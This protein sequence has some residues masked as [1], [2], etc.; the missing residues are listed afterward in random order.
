MM[1]N[2]KSS[3]TSEPDV[4]SDSLADVAPCLQVDEPPV[5]VVL[6]QPEIPQNTG[7]IG[8]TCVAVGAKLW[9]V[10]PLGFKIDEHSVRRA[11]VDYWHML[12]LQLVDSIGEVQ[13]ALPQR[14]FWYFSR[15][16][17]RS[18][19]EAEIDLGD[20][21]VFGRESAGLPEEILDLDSPQAIRIP[22]TEQVRSL[23]LSN[24]AAIAV[25]EVLRQHGRLR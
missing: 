23:N 21:I 8:R 6:Y 14:K 22:T 16:A 13:Q 1:D 24:T 5:H 20:A 10:R 7:N 11:G 3:D 2:E 19:W 25:Y 12:N 15:F 18:L 4:P 9:L 17:R